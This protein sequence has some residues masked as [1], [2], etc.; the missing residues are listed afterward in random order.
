MKI[1]ER[2]VLH[3]GLGYHGM[4]IVLAELKN[5]YGVYYYIHCEDRYSEAM[6]T[7]DE[8]EAREY[9]RREVKTARIK[10]AIINTARKRVARGATREDI[11]KYQ[12][13]LGSI[14]GLHPDIKRHVDHLEWMVFEG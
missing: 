12:D 1:I 2:T 7:T 3:E 4:S 10:Q 5:G 13:Y 9:F 6:T 11:R 8:A 14:W